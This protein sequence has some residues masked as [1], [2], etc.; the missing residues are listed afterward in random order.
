MFPKIKSILYASDLSNNSAPALAWAILLAHR[1]DARVTLLHVIEEAYPQAT[2]FTRSILG[3]D[4]WKA[5]SDG[6]RNQTQDLIK[7]QIECFCDSVLQEMAACPLKVAEILIDRGMPVEIILKQIAS[8]NYDL[9]TMGALGAGPFKK[10]A[11]GRTARHV[12]RSSRFPVFMVPVP[13]PPSVAVQ[14]ID[15][16]S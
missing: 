15:A 5:V 12:L 2:L 16:G 14:Q 9:V 6:R 13:P 3:D 8:N 4:R 11:L 10:S 7:E 1:H